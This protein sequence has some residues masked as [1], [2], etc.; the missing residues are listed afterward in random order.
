MTDPAPGAADSEDL[1]YTRQELLRLL[2]DLAQELG[3]TPTTAE[4]DSAAEYPSKST[5]TLRFG[6]WNE[7]VKLANLEPNRPSKYSDEELS[8]RLAEFA[9]ETGKTPTHEDVRES[10]EMPSATVYLKRWE[11]WNEAVEE[12]GLEPRTSTGTRSD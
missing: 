7:A 6:S 10:D 1:S 5:Y 9:E 3:K 11:T 4:L 8:Q 12:A 2:Q